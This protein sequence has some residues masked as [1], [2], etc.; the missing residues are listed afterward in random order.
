[1][2]FDQLGCCQFQCMIDSTTFYRPKYAEIWAIEAVAAIILAPEPNNAGP[3]MPPLETQRLII[4]D[5]QPADAGAMFAYM[6]HEP[7]WRDLPIE[8][9]TAASV[10]AMI[11]ARVQDQA[12]EPRTSYFLAVADQTSGQIIGEAILTIRSTRWRQSEIGWAVSHDRTG[13]GIATEI[14]QALLDLAFDKLEQHRV[15]AQCRLENRASRQVMAKLGMREEAIL[16][17]NVLA[18]GAWWSS[19]QCAMLKTEYQLP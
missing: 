19:V 1:V 18:R 10:A 2:K 11:D 5:V 9:P 13:Q 16:R 3:P 17:E 8:P 15:Y 7:Y 14:G 12:R 4:R 6:R